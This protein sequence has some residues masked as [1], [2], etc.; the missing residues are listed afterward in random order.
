M[1][2]P[3]EA[4]VCQIANSI[5]R[6][7]ASLANPKEDHAEKIDVVLTYNGRSIGLQVSKT[8]KS[9]KESKKLLKRGVIPISTHK[10]LGIK[11]SESEIRNEIITA[12]RTQ[13]N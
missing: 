1:A 3:D 5:E 12:I 6:V 13:F 9:K 10:F 4:L 2:N 8:G 7:K 11:K